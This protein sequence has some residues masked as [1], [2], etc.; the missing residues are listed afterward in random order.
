MQKIIFHLCCI[1]DDAHPLLS[2]QVSCLHGYLLSF[3]T[4]APPSQSPPERTSQ[5]RVTRTAEVAKIVNVFII[6]L[7][8]RVF[9]CI[10]IIAQNIRN[11]SKPKCNRSTENMTAFLKLTFNYSICPTFNNYILKAPLK[12]NSISFPIL[13]KS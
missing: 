7:S 11:S 4:P 12:K 10:L 2:N 9:I 3:W 1:D 6:I 8:S 5:P 13:W